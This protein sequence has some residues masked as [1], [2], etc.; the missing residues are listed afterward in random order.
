MEFWEFTGVLPELTGHRNYHAKWF[1]KKRTLEVE[2]VSFLN[3]PV[4][5]SEKIVDKPVIWR[6]EI[7]GEAPKD[8][9]GHPLCIGATSRHA[10][11]Q[12]ISR[13]DP[14]VK[15]WLADFNMKKIGLFPDP[16]KYFHK[17]NVLIAPLE[18]IMGPLYGP[19]FAVR[20][21]I[22]LPLEVRC[23][24]RRS[25]MFFFE[26]TGG[27]SVKLYKDRK[28]QSAA[29]HPHEKEILILRGDEISKK[30]HFTI[31]DLK[32][33]AEKKQFSFSS[34]MKTQENVS[35]DSEDSQYE[36]Q[37]IRLKQITL[38]FN[39]TGDIVVFGLFLLHSDIPKFEIRTFFYGPNEIMLL[40]SFPIEYQ[41]PA[42]HSGLMLPS[43]NAFMSLSL[44]QNEHSFHYRVLWKGSNKSLYMGSLPIGDT[45]RLAKL[46]RGVVRSI[47]KE[48]DIPKLPVPEKIKLFLIYK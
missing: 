4:V 16:L 20:W 9:I 11:F 41:I 24:R 23:P 28:F 7:D 27:L 8:L 36:C 17:S 32:T 3:E 44:A 31:I 1:Q 12:V 14:F 15:F 13:C 48:D 43:Q 45:L 21:V 38:L 5:A 25:E 18:C 22:R 2:S 42:P 29:Y 33:L 34:L 6:C 37:E 47:V 19:S 30:I 10:V 35:D 39:L 40:Q 26:Y 46:C